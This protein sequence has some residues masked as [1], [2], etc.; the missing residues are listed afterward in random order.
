MG[1]VFGTF[2]TALA[3]PL[4]KTSR[5]STLLSFLF[6]H[7]AQ[8]VNYNIFNIILR[9]KQ[10]ISHYNNT[11]FLSRCPDFYCH[12]DKNNPNAVRNHENREAARAPGR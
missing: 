8:R 6:G 1:V 3:H 2:F 12:A 7:A 10:Q 4:L 11:R 9:H 5:P